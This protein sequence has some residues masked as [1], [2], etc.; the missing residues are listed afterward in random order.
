MHEMDDDDD[1]MPMERP[2][3]DQ[4]PPIF[5]EEDDDRFVGFAFLGDLGDGDFQGAVLLA[6]QFGFFTA[7]LSAY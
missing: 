4:E 7:R 3:F 5:A 1:E 2:S 6:T